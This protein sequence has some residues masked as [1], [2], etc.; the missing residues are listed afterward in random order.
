MLL[1]THATLM[2]TLNR[3][4]GQG[5]YSVMGGA[6]MEEVVPKNE[7]PAAQMKRLAKGLDKE[8]PAEKLPILDLMIQ[9]EIAGETLDPKD[10]Y[11]QAIHDEVLEAH[12][13]AWC[14]RAAA[15]NGKFQPQEI[16]K[17][18][19]KYLASLEILKERALAKDDEAQA[20]LV[21]K[22]VDSLLAANIGN[23]DK[24]RI[25]RDELAAVPRAKGL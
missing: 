18:G 24:L 23:A 17:F 2:P 21:K 3:L 15:A 19:A 16:E 20:N 13:D 6:S 1:Y 12:P 11:L 10:R 22:T 7:T 25:M 9:K 5:K 8:D 4:T 14:A